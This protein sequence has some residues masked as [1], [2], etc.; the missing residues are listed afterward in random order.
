MIDYSKMIQLGKKCFTNIPCSNCGKIITR[1]IY[2]SSLESEEDIFCSHKCSAE[3]KRIKRDYDIDSKPARFQFEIIVNETMGECVLC[4]Q[5]NL[6]GDGLCK[7]CWDEHAHNILED[8]IKSVC[9]RCGKKI[10]TVHDDG[11]SIPETLLCVECAKETIDVNSLKC[12]SCG[13]YSMYIRGINKGKID[14][15]CKSCNRT[16][17]NPVT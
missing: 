11:N 9:P 5:Y 4:G 8:I 7:N 10:S 17:V 6:L 14:Y 15:Q 13:N 2:N 1:K 3:Y 16:T 12:P